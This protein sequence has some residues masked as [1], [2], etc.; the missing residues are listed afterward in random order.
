MP[1]LRVGCTYDRTTVIKAISTFPRRC[2]HYEGS[3]TIPWLESARRSTKTRCPPSTCTHLFM[4]RY[5]NGQ[6]HG[7]YNF[8]LWKTEDMSSWSI[9]GPEDRGHKRRRSFVSPSTTATAVDWPRNV[10]QKASVG[11]L[12]GIPSRL[13][14]IG[15]GGAESMSSA[16]ARC[17]FSPSL[18]FLLASTSSLLAPCAELQI[19]L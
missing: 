16:P 15:V 6:R 3:S 10:R 12:P 17:L 7:C 5:T 13:L 8:A 14:A 18:V 2:K 4:T 1:H 9:E 19:N 11:E